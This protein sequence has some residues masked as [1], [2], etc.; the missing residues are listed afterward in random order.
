MQ[1]Q[2]IELMQQAVKAAEQDFKSKVETHQNL[3]ERHI[4]ATWTSEYEPTEP[5]D[6]ALLTEAA[7]RE[8]IE[9]KR[10]VE[11]ALQVYTEAVIALM[12]ARASRR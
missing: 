1:D 8:M 3:R 9:A 4:P 5:P 10:G 11:E 2:T 12:R 7:I 6:R